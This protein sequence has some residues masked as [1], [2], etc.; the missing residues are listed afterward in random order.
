[1]NKSPIKNEPFENIVLLYDKKIN[2]EIKHYESNPCEIEDLKQEIYIKILRNFLNINESFGPWGWIRKVVV[3]HCK[4][5]IR[6]KSRYKFVDA[7]ISENINLIDNLP[8]EK[9]LFNIDTDQ[10]YIQKYVYKAV[11]N[12]E[13]KFREVIILYDFENLNY[14]EIS[15]KVGCPIGTVKSRLFRARMQLKQELKHLLYQ[16]S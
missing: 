10:E 15:K 3:N 11:L 4:N 1:M 6:H 2:R 9:F 13:K 16:G 14:E 5:H 12:L 7:H 8:D